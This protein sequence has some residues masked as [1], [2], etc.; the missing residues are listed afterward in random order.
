MSFYRTIG[1]LVL[2]S[3]ILLINCSPLIAY[4]CYKNPKHFSILTGKL[5]GD[6]GD[7]ET[8]KLKKKEEL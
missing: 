7:D 3:V 5:K 8:L 4:V 6:V 1:P 2:E